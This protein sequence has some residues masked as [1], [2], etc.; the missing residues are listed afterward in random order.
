MLQRRKQ[1][2]GNKNI[3]M[4][5]S[6]ENSDEMDKFLEKHNLPKGKLEDKNSPIN[7]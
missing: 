2:R 5:E 4:P 7:K 3:F 6:F 1:I